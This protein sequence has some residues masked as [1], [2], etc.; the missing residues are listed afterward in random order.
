MTLI[1][2]GT[3]SFKIPIREENLCD[4]SKLLN[5]IPSSFLFLMVP[6]KCILFLICPLY[7]P[8]YKIIFFVRVEGA[9]KWPYIIAIH[10]ALNIFKLSNYLAMLHVR[11]YDL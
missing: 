3:L 11:H 5:T 8:S 4:Y 9:L 1:I 10:K 7:R 2:P 6:T